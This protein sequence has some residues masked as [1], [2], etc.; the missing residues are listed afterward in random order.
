MEGKSSAAM[1]NLRYKSALCYDQ[2]VRTTRMTNVCSVD[3]AIERQ[4]RSMVNLPYGS[5]LNLPSPRRALG[6]FG[7]PCSA[8]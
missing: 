7:F 5:F 1:Q 4:W 8:K 3:F 2:K 6:V